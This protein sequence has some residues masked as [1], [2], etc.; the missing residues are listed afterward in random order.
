MTDR[1]ALEQSAETMMERL[2]R[3]RK[4]NRISQRK[5]RERDRE[6]REQAQSRG[7]ES[8]R[9]ERRTTCHDSRLA[10]LEQQGQDEIAPAGGSDYRAPAHSHGGL[11][12]QPSSSTSASRSW[13]S[14][15]MAECTSPFEDGY[16]L[17]KGGP[18]W[19]CTETAG[20][21]KDEGT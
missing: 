11:A 7:P 6:R 8:A 10:P 13:N 15:T 20:T 4:Q 12:V 3:R 18:V 1:A 16:A 17:L 2:E 5:R 21:R 9:T 14:P 19:D